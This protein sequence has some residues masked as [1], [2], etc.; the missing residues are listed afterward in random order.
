MSYAPRRTRTAVR[1]KS[2]LDWPRGWERTEWRR[3]GPF[4]DTTLYVEI[5][6]K[7]YGRNGVLAELRLLG[8]DDVVVSTNLQL[9]RDGL[10]Y[11]NQKQPA[12]P[13]VA[14]WFNLGGE[15]R[16]LAC[17]RYDR[18]EQNLRAIVVHVAAMRGMERWGVGSMA[19]AFAGFTPLPEQAGGRPWWEILGVERTASI[20]QIESAYRRRAR[21]VHPD[22]AGSREGWDEL[23]LAMRQAK[24][25][26]Q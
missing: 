10:P 5:N 13:G 24:E 11:S 1:S 15:E 6:G 20:G 18:V 19:Q 12:D 3:P 17:D 23:E 25:A 7:G 21:D 8:A 22:L 26:Q 9:R 2:P 16:V 14:V 4:D